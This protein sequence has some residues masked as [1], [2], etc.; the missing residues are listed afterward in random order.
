MNGLNAAQVAE[1]VSAGRTNEYRERTSRSAAQILRANVFTIFNG[2][3]GVALVL[4]LALGHWADALF[5]F[6]LLLN[7]ATGTLA[8]IR[9]KRALDRLAVLETPRAVVLRDGTEIEVAVGEVVIDDVVR[10]RAGQQVPA[11][12]EVLVSDGLEID[13]SILTGESRPV[14][15]VSGAQVMSG[16]TVTAGTGLFRTTAVG[17]DAYAH[18]LAREARRYSLV[19]S[20]LQAG[21]NR[22]LHWISWVIV[23]VALVLVWSQLRLSGSIA[24]TWSSG[25]W[26]HAVVAGIAGVVSMV[27]QGLVLLTS[28]NF[29]TAS[30]SLARRNVLVQELPAVEVLARVDTLCLDKTG[31]IT[32]GRIRLGEVQGPGGDQAPSEVLS[33]L[34]LLSTVGEANAT[35]DAIREGLSDLRGLGEQGLKDARDPGDTGSSADVES[36]PFSS[37]RKWSAVRDRSGTTWVLGAPE[38]VLAGHSE[39]VLDRAR[40]IAAQGVRVV[41][42][43][44]SGSPWRSAPGEDDPRLP[45]HLE[46]AGIVILT[47]EIRPDAAE[48]LAYFRQQGVD[49]KVISGDSPETV[50]AVARQ[51]GVTA[52]GG[53]ELVAL[54][55]RTLPAGAGGG[56]EAEE[57][58]ERLADAVEGA[59]VL[60]R[61][62]PEQKRALVRALKSRGHVVAMTGDGVNDAL[63]LKD[64]DLGI[65]MGNGAP[66]TKAVARLVLLKGEFSALPGVVAQGRRVMANTERIASL[67]LAKTIYASLIAVVVSAM[68]VAYP[69]LPRQFTV[70]SSLTIGIPAFVL[71]LA[72]S[73]QRYR[74]GFLGRV[75]SLCVPAGLMAGTVTLSTYLW[76]TLTHAPRAQ[77]TTATTLVL[78]TCGLWLLTLTA[79]PLTSWRLG[80]VVLMGAIAVL[81]VVAPPVRA[82]FLLAWPTPGVWWVIALMAC[83]AIV[84]I[85]LVHLV[86]RRIVRG[87]G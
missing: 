17:G 84:G 63:A 37:R 71:A 20:E 40:Q 67:F 1:R 73:N 75:L 13:E 53:G 48:T 10:L 57:D 28:V 3:L 39:S 19:V 21:T 68:A 31:T 64:A 33:A 86:R 38:I 25:A 78:I 72:P 77:V 45:D 4:V 56:Q 55:A 11:D 69:F 80:L 59:S 18:R 26:R 51:A 58:L 44:R 14:R 24:E 50:A 15:P 29:A 36:V 74:Q 66:A 65:A 70:V 22:V 42:L 12:G 35:A 79:R 61:V 76:L 46:A 81:G 43:A 62:T 60:G 82:F 34:A 27:P 49:A 5:G 16:T 87:R 85:E 54:D 23:P 83:L 52:P 9:A 7:T 41:A 30:L 47:E 2:I 32:T 6:V 8:E